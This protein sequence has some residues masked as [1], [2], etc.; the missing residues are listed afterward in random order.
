MTKQ[1][2]ISNIEK[3]N[4]AMLEYGVILS[5]THPEV[6]FQPHHTSPVKSYLWYN[7][8]LDIQP[9]TFVDYY[10]EKLGITTETDAAVEISKWNHGLYNGTFPIVL[11]DKIITIGDLR[12]GVMHTD[13]PG[14]S[15]V[16]MNINLRYP[17]QL[18]IHAGSGGYRW[19]YL[20]PQATPSDQNLKSY[21]G[22]NKYQR[23]RFKK[24]W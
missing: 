20:D 4:P 11:F 19:Q 5:E 6:D 16:M 15:I 23:D 12:F 21:F 14:K 7:F 22:I 24:Q 3:L 9:Y 13:D 10:Q 18:N 2:I 17:Y 1:L 8:H